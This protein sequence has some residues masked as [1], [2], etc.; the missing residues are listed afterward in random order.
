MEALDNKM[1][2]DMKQTIDDSV[3]SDEFGYF[4]DSL[5]NLETDK[6]IFEKNIL[7]KSCLGGNQNECN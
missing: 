1:I 2:R 6:D 3:F 7:N 5:A 4:I